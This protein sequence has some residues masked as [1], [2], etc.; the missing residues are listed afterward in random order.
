MQFTENQ[1]ALVESI[2]EKHLGALRD[3]IYAVFPHFD[4]TVDDV[5]LDRSS[6]WLKYGYYVA[7]PARV[8][9]ED[10]AREFRSL[11]YWA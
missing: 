5:E 4:I 1:K 11:P 3:E 7:D 8:D 2:V 6:N 10:L 9:A